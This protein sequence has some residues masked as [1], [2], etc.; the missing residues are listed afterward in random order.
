L[1]SNYSNNK[2]WERQIFW[3]SREWKCTNSMTLPDHQ[4]IPREWRHLN[5]NRIGRPKLSDAEQSKVAHMFDYYKHH[6]KSENNFDVIIT[7]RAMNEHL[8]YSLPEDKV[9]LTKAG[10]PRNVK[11]KVP[12]SSVSTDTERRP[13]KTKGHSFKASEK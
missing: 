1:K 13:P 3:V 10:K 6:H 12:E 8:G 5:R 9:P 4:R 2:E 7:A 11:A